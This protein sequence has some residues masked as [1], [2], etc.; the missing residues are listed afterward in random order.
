MCLQRIRN[1]S[2]RSSSGRLSQLGD[3]DNKIGNIKNLESRISQDIKQYR[4]GELAEYSSQIAENTEDLLVEVRQIKISY[5]DAKQFKADKD[6]AK[7]IARFSKT[8]YFEQMRLNPVRHP[9][10]C[11]WFRG[12]DKYRAWLKSTQND[13]LLVTAEPGCGKSVLSRCLIEQDLPS[14]RRPGNNK[15]PIVCYFFFKDNTIQSSLVNALG[16]IIYQLLTECKDTAAEFAMEINSMSDEMLQGSDT[17][18]SLFERVSRH[19]AFG[20]RTVY[21]VFDALDECAEDGRS[22]LINLLQGYLKYENEAPG[23]I[24]RHQSSE[25]KHRRGLQG[26]DREASTT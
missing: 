6:L 12:H 5:A 25:S 23:S 2:C 9:G 14:R 1:T 18:W 24:S 16:A 26:M 13:L 10:T 21:C 3:W 17:L 19:K 15:E 7:L 11:K 4:L 20:N 8:T 22:K